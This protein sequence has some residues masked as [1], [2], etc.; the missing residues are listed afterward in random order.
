MSSSLVNNKAQTKANN[1]KFPVRLEEKKNVRYR[2]N[3]TNIF[4]T[5]DNFQRLF[6][7]YNPNLLCSYLIFFVQLLHNTKIIEY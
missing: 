7:Y 3:N 2:K 1:R 4:H 6:N 5:K